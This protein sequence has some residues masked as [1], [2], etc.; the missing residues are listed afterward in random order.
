MH[1]VFLN[2]I[3]ELP[4]SQLWQ[5]YKKYHPNGTMQDGYG[6]IMQ[7]VYYL[8]LIDVSKVNRKKNGF[9]VYHDYL[10]LW[11]VHGDCSIMQI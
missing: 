2:D 8:T 1:V 5:Y 11:I 6:F 3:L 7:T 4:A 9:K 10:I